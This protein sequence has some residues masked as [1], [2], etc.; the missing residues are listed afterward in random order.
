[1][2]RQCGCVGVACA[3]GKSNA[4]EFR[5]LIFNRQVDAGTHVMCVLNETCNFTLDS[6][7]G[8]GTK[9]LGLERR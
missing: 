5:F 3:F 9:L 7:V 4:W 8:C 2:Q 1:M 6:M